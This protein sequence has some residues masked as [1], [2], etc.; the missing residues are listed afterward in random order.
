METPAYQ[1]IC[2]IFITF[3]GSIISR[4]FGSGVSTNH[5]IFDTTCDAF[6]ELPLNRR[7]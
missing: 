2:A 1:P 5:S 4:F 3:F 7:L 6:E